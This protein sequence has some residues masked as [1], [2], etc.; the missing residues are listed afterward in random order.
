MIE[1][2]V[3][4]DIGN[5]NRKLLE[6]VGTYSVASSKGCSQKLPVGSNPTTYLPTG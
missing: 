5:L 1:P 2:P 4:V 3:D 6:L